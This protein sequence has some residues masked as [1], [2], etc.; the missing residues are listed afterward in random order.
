MFHVPGFIDGPFHHE[1]DLKHGRREVTCKP[2]NKYK[3]SCLA[4]KT[5]NQLEEREIRVHKS[6]LKIAL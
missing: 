5:S 3:I 2:A 4:H 1:F 6:D